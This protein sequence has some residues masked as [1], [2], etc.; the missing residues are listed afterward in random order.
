MTVS[1]PS[2]FAWLRRVPVFSRLGEGDCSAL[3]S[4]LR[5]LRLMA[6][7]V[8][9]RPGELG[10]SLAVVADGLL[11][12]EVAIPD[13]GRVE[14][15]RLQPGDVVG[16]MACIDPA[17][18]TALVAAYRESTVYLLHRADFLALREEAPQAVVAL[19]GGVLR[20]LTRRLRDMDKRIAK[21]IKAPPP[22]NPSFGAGAATTAAR[23]LPAAGASRGSPVSTTSLGPLPS[24]PGFSPS[25]VPLLSGVAPSLKF[26]LGEWLCIEGEPGTCCY[27]V[28]QGSIEVIKKMEEG[29]QVLA[30]LHPGS[31][32]GQL[33]LLDRSPRS[34]SLRAGEAAVVLA[35]ERDL[36][37]RLVAAASPVGLRF[38]EQVAIAGIRQVR[39]ANTRLASLLAS[40]QS[41]GKDRATAPLTGKD[42]VFAAYLQA[43]LTHWDLPIDNAA[44]T[45]PSLP[46][47]PRALGKMML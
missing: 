42:R 45:V 41:R 28:L 20:D 18:R 33:A 9:F 6:G 2:P 35:L 25:D 8:L 4:R 19:L 12:V 14:L 29:H 17:P 36:F 30:T 15:A 23:S 5:P 22:S 11:V 44:A 7:N 37:Q 40:P 34:A 32:V 46:A 26:A 16:E 43:A 24:F 1:A 13:G 47:R 21:E 27:L 39:S 38:Q 3:A 31:V 10:D